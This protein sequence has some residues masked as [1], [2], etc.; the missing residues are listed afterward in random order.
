MGIVGTF[1]FPFHSFFSVKIPIPTILN[2]IPILPNNV[3]RRRDTH[4]EHTGCDTPEMGP[5]KG[6]YIAHSRCHFSVH[7][8]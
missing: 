8:T 1:T 2:K 6:F 3:S 7:S 5:L 4:M